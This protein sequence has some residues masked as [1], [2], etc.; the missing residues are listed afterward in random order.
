MPGTVA[1]SQQVE[2][3]PYSTTTPTQLEASSTS[4]LPSFPRQ[5]PPHLEASMFGQLIP[6][7]A[8]CAVHVHL[9]VLKVHG[10]L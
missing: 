5:Q 3:P 10:D 6:A 8:C 9:G 1:S 4:D 2:M 7:N